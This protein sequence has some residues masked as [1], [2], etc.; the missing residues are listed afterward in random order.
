MSLYTFGTFNKINM[1]VHMALEIG[2]SKSVCY[3]SI[4]L[5]TKLDEASKDF[6]NPSQTSFNHKRTSMTLL[7]KII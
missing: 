1:L 3:S 5:K 7:W 2:I 6:I 4:I